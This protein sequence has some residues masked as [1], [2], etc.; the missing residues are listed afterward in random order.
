MIYWNEEPG[1]KTLTVNQPG[2]YILTLVNECDSIS[3]EINIEEYP[4]PEVNLGEDKVIMT[5]ETLELDAG[6]G[7]D[8]YTW[9]DGSGGRYYVISDQNMNPQ[10]PYYYVEVKDGMCFNSDTVKIEL[11]EVWVPIVITPNGDGWNDIFEPDMNSWHRIQDHKIEVF[12]RWG[13]KVWE[14]Q[15]FPGG[16]DGKRNGKYVA[17]GTYYWILEVYYGSEMIKQTLKGSL[18]IIGTGD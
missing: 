10:D 16:W 3:D 5:G 13:E 9:Q 12:S 14:S 4:L 8:A 15:D 18:T 6:A 11:F 2:E 7:Y 1:G 17:E